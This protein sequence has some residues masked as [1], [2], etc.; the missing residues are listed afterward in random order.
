MLTGRHTHATLLHYTS[1]YCQQ[2][3]AIWE[4]HKNPHTINSPHRQ[5]ET[6]ISAENILVAAVTY[7]IPDERRANIN[8]MMKQKNPKVIAPRI[9]RFLKCNV[10]LQVLRGASEYISDLHNTKLLYEILQC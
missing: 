7:L 4:L 8:N 6:L 5:A 3:N 2:S 1:V 10:L 9:I